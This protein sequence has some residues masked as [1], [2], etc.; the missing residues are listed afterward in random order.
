V[1][2]KPTFNKIWLIVALVIIGNI[3]LFSALSRK[4]ESYMVDTMV[5]QHD[6]ELQKLLK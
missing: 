6:I 3:I 5:E 4:L 2:V 1:G